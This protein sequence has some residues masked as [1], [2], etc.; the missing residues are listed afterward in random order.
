MLKIGK[1]CSTPLY[2]QADGRFQT[3][4]VGFEVGLSVEDQVELHFPDG[5]KKSLSK[6]AGDHLTPLELVYDGRFDE[7]KTAYK[8]MMQSDP[9][10]EIV[11]DAEFSE[12][13]I[14][15]YWDVVKDRGRM[16]ARKLARNILKIA[17]DLLPEAP[18]SEYSLRF[19]R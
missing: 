16:E 1:F 6:L 3:E 14:L 2:P 18:S 19:Y 7:A 5:R 8:E 10:G 4:L 15:A 17:I 13:A 11:S 9:K 12:L